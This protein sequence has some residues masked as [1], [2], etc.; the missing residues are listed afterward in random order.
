MR[1]GLFLLN[2]R[3]MCLDRNA[4]NW[5]ITLGSFLLIMSF[6]WFYHDVTFGQIDSESRWCQWS[7]QFQALNLISIYSSY[8]LIAMIKDCTIQ[9]YMIKVRN[10][11]VGKVAINVNGWKLITRYILTIHS[12]ISNDRWP[13][14]DLFQSH[15]EPITVNVPIGYKN[16]SVLVTIVTILVSWIGSYYIARALSRKAAALKNRL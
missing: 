16:F 5:T 12:F 14:L 6:T 3:N 1:S 9:H 10:W 13:L 8:S 7:Y 4:F 2:H 15:S 11:S